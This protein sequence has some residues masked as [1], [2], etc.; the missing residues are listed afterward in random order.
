M[1]I[2]KYNLPYESFTT[3]TQLTCNVAALHDGCYPRPQIK[4]DFETKMTTI[5]ELAGA[6]RSW[7]LAPHGA[8]IM[9]ECG[10]STKRP[11]PTVVRPPP[12]FEPTNAESPKELSV[13]MSASCATLTSG[14]SPAEAEADEREEASL[15]FFFAVVP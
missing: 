7:L 2:M 9:S 10:A 11:P 12:F 3:P 4:T 8:Q 1:R 14:A 6:S 15:A 13:S 5:T